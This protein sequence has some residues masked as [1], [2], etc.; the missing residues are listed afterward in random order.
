MFALSSGEWFL[1]IAAFFTSTFTAI[2][3]VGGGILLLSLMPGMITPAAVIPVHAAVQLFSNGSR[4]LFSWRSVRKKLVMPYILGAGIGVLAGSQIVLSINAQYLPA[5]LGTMILMITW[6]PKRIFGYLSGHYY[7]FGFIS[8]FISTIAGASG[9][10]VAA[11]L[12][13]EKLS[14]DS[15]VTTTATFMTISHLLKIFAFGLFGFA[16]SGYFSLVAMMIVMVA[17]GSWAGTQ[18]RGKVPPTHFKIIIKW[19]ITAL[20]LRM[21]CIAFM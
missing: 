3:G 21:Y 10:L 1:V 16:F 8:T 6:M 13:R 14:R 15:L 17:A 12:S 20:A 7:S 19:L 2:F 11:F 18:I 5:M 9:P 4:V